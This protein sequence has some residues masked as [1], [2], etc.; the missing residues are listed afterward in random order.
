MNKSL[1][2]KGD[3]KKLMREYNVRIQK[4][5]SKHT[6]GIIERYNRILIERLFRS[7]DTSDLLNL[8]ERFQI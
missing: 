5:E 1:E 7:Q 3:C 4:A 8:I 2:F 6:M